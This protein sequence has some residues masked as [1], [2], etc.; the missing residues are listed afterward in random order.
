M[1]LYPHIS[2]VDPDGRLLWSSIEVM[3]VNVMARFG[4]EDS[5]AEVFLHPH[6]PLPSCQLG[7]GLIIRF[8]STI[9][10]QGTLVEIQRQTVGSPLVLKACR[11]P[12]RLF[13]REVR[14]LYEHQSPTVILSSI[15][16]ST[17]PHQLWCEN[18]PAS[19]RE[20]DRLDFRGIPLFYAVDLLAKLAGNWL[21]WIDWE[22]HLHF[23]S[24]DSP[25][26][27]EWY[28]HEDFLLLSPR[29]SDYR[30][31][32]DFEFHG[33]VIEGEEF[34]RTFSD[35]GSIELYGR[36]PESLFAR[37][38]MTPLVFEYL[39]EAVIE[40]LPGPGYSRFIQRVDG[41]L[42]AFFGERFRL[43]GNLPAGMSSG[44]VFR[45]AGEEIAWSEKGL[46]TRYHLA[47]GMESASRY[48]RYLDH[49][50]L[51]VDFVGSQ[52]GWFTLDLS[53]LDSEVRLGHE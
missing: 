44:Q 36:S 11:R 10:F 53:S 48:T 35:A 20:L 13:Q 51:T 24:P 49:E 2:I 8:G 50:P 47:S 30:V 42:D 5:E 6:S 29:L 19:N 3:K 39:R 41:G 45:I 14:G 15:L 9:R 31:K 27:H 22:D 23:I 37:A 18:Q 4:A 1:R 26:E 33:G 7:D 32:N 25:P 40:E 52:L 46:S 28:V 21:W 34:I 12:R 38:V 17:Y 16:L 43:R